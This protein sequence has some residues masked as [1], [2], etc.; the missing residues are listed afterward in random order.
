M[1][2]IISLLLCVL[3]TAALCV[4]AAAD[5]SYDRLLLNDK[6]VNGNNVMASYV[7]INEGDHLYLLGWAVNEQA[8]SKL[9]E[10]FYT[11]DGKEY[12]C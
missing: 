9:K 10:A 8:E 4:S 3:F 1:K 5:T 7:T 2:K 12:K 6:K 11:V